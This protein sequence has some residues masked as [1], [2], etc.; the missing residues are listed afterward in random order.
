MVTAAP[1][2][3]LAG[4]SGSPENAFGR[5]K[6]RRS[7]KCGTPPGSGS[8][9]VS[10]KRPKLDRCCNFL[11]G[12]ELNHRHETRRGR[13]AMGFTR[14]FDRADGVAVLCAQ[15]DAQAAPGSGRIV[16]GPQ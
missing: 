2:K 9:K 8:S 16:T 10:S 3:K 4:S 11:V 14:S 6:R 7:G 15:R 13:K 5:L 12:S 1:S